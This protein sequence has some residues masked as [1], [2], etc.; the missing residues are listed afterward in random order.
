MNSIGKK[1]LIL[2]AALLSLSA[3]ADAQAGNSH[4]YHG[5]HK[6]AHFAPRPIHR[7]V[8]H[9][10]KHRHHRHAHK[11]RHGHRA[12]HYPRRYLRHRAAHAHRHHAPYYDVAPRSRGATIWVDGIGFSIYS[13]H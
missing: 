3:F 4:G 9:G 2:S 6:A 12:H 1:L 10:H 7:H 11:F 13:S 5:A 8:R